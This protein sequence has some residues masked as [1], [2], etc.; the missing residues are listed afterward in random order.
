MSISDILVGVNSSALDVPLN[1]TNWL[2]DYKIN[3]QKSYVYK[4]KDILHELY[5]SPI[6]ANDEDI[7]MEAF[8]YIVSDYEPYLGLWLSKNYGFRD[9]TNLPNCKSI[10]DIVSDADALNRITTSEFADAF[11]ALDAVTSGFAT[12]DGL[13]TA[14]SN[15]AL[16]TLLETSDSFKTAVASNPDVQTLSK[17]L[18]YNESFTVNNVFLINVVAESVKNGNSYIRPSVGYTLHGSSETTIVS[19]VEYYGESYAPVSKSP[20]KFAKS[21]K[22]TGTIATVP[23]SITYIQLDN[24]V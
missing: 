13:K 16:M 2:L 8:D 18:G 12:T 11:F 3:G 17:S 21:V 10:S 4:D 9:L 24:V 15:D 22:I 5:R 14:S 7:Q 20:N 19:T 1:H 23:A 6:S